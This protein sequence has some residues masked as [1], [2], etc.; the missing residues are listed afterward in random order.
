MR[1][2]KKAVHEEEPDEKGPGGVCGVQEVP[3]LAEDAGAVVEQP[4]LEEE[5]LEAIRS[6]VLERPRAQKRMK[7]VVRQ[8]STALGMR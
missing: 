1:N 3:G 4:K 6:L 7:R 5:E 2:D 8:A